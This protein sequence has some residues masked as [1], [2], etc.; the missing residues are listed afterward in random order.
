MIN[1]TTILYVLLCLLLKT[2]TAT[3]QITPA[4][5][6]T[7]EYLP[8]LKNKKVGVVTNHTGLIEKTHLV[9]SLLNLDI[10]ITAIFCPEHGFRGDK[11]AGLTIESSTDIKTGIKIISLY[12][13]NKKPT[14]NDLRNIDVLLFDM[15]DVGVRYY[16]YISTMHYVMEAAAENRKQVI[17]LDRPNPNG[18]YIDGPVLDMTYSSFVGMH[19]IPV[20]YGMTIGELAL[21]INGE[22]W[23]KNKIKCNITVIECE[24]YTHNSRYML[25][26]PPSPNLPCMEAVYLYPSLGFFEGTVVSEGRGTHFPFQTY[27]HPLLKG[28]PFEFTPVSIPEA[29]KPKFNNIKC[30]GEDLR[31]TMIA[32]GEVNELTLIYL[33]NSYRQLKLTDFFNS[34]FRYLA[35]NNNLQKQIED[36]TDIEDI[37]ASWSDDL[38]KFKA[39]RQKYLLYEDF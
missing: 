26:V 4:A 8:M 25:P 35:G 27:G 15:Q 9:D 5:H 37:R 1:K 18:F 36:N 22:G 17:V 39:V 6:R 38:E 31:N 2:F 32:K 23:L 19:P 21:M 33:I 16:T 12:G 30:Y 28:L 7:G 10:S 13:N 3:A 11:E 14:A 20:V 29:T 24:N 34:F